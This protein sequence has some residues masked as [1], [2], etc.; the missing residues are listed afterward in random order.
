MAAAK[1]SKMSVMR[2]LSV[3]NAALT[4]PARHP[5]PE[6]ST[7]MAEM[8]QAPFGGVV[9]VE[10]VMAVGAGAGAA[11]ARMAAQDTTKM[12][13]SEAANIVSSTCDCGCTGCFRTI[14]I[15]ELTASAGGSTGRT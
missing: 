3:A 15:L 6:V 9:D 11:F 4:V 12:V 8:V 5:L 7:E 10:G 2:E 1:S 14:S 13:K